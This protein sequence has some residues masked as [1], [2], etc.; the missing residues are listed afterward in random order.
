VPQGHTICVATAA[1]AA[2]A[3]HA[4]PEEVDI[5]EQRVEGLQEEGGADSV[6]GEVVLQGGSGERKGGGGAVVE[7]C[8]VVEEDVDFDGR[9]GGEE[10][11]GEGGD[12]SGRGDVAGEDVD[13]G[14]SGWVGLHGAQGGEV[15]RDG[16]DEGEDGVGGD[17]GELA[18]VFEAEA[19]AGA[20]DYVDG[21]FEGV[22]G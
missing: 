21:H 3:H 2:Q 18:D 5:S 8:G 9:V 1:E 10:E 15:A 19:G 16:A 13:C 12:G 17:G 22:C 11:C 6:G 7:D 20:G 4:D 14:E